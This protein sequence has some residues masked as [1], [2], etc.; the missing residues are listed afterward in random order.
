VRSRAYLHT[1]GGNAYHNATKT[2]GLVHFERYD[3]RDEHR[4]T[5]IVYRKHDIITIPTPL[6]YLPRLPEILTADVH[7]DVIAISSAMR[8]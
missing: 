2:T 8:G 7:Y 3:C 1:F 6:K 4:I 5:A